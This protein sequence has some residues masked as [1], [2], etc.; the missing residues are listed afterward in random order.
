MAIT[1]GTTDSR[2]VDSRLTYE[3]LT[4]EKRMTLRTFLVPVAMLAL[5]ACAHKPGQ[6]AAAVPD[7]QQQPPAAAV[8]QPANP[9]PAPQTAAGP[10]AAV[11]PPATPQ[12]EPAQP[13]AM[14]VAQT[15]PKSSHS[16][17]SP[18]ENRAAAEAPAQA[19][20]P[21]TVTIPSGTR[22]RVRLGETLDTKTAR[23]GEG[24]IAHLD[25]PI[26]LDNQVVVPKGTVFHGHVVESKSS[27]RLK[28]RAY[29]GVVLDSFELRG[30]TYQV[31]TGSDVR[32][33]GSHKKR[34]LVL[35]GGGSGVGAAIGA[36]AG[37]GVGALI[38]AGAGAAAGTTGA[39]ITGKKNVRL[40][41]ETPMTFSLQNAVTVRA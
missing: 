1:T 26:M 29:L 22:V 21:A 6:Q 14:P 20:K 32:A 41:A 37:G 16:K 28:G 8:A 9:T 23:A 33:S 31:R 39:L 13:A 11:T 12:V 7:A 17:S 2:V 4:E 18:F 24:F 36:I 30:V 27:G 35:M 25:A 10:V 5:A 34:N 3:K 15:A 19:Q 40:P 38:G